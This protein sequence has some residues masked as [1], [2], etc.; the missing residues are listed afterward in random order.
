MCWRG[1]VCGVRQAG[2]LLRSGVCVDRLTQLLH[3]VWRAR[4]GV[5]GL[6]GLIPLVEACGSIH[7]ASVVHLFA[8]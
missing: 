3:C 8:D 5:G 6:R 4:S 2:T 7:T 1:D